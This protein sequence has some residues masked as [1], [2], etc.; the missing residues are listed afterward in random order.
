MKI[1]EIPIAAI[2]DGGRLRP[3]TDEAASKLAADI[4]ERGL[5][6]PIEVQKKTA[7]RWLLVSGAHRLAGC[8]LLGWERI[9]AVVIPEG[10]MER[11][12]DE[13]LENLARREMTKLERCQY[14]AAFRELY[15]EQHPEAR[16]GGD[17]RSADFKTNG[18][19][20]WSEEA[21]ERCPH[22]GPRSAQRYAA[23]GD[24]LD[25]DAADALRET[26]IADKL[27]ELDA[28]SRQTP[29]R[30]RR[31]ATLLAAGDPEVTSVAQARRS[32]RR[33]PRSGA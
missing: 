22:M 24:S 14:V 4:A 12:R 9:P 7:D 1:I 26:D 29:E 18:D 27:T 33:A 5:R 16:R 13:L 21:A 10:T 15:I 11:R 6:Q 8:R 17:R 20:V 2:D 25:P 23:I 28:L 30:Q 19:S 31:I 32:S 3:V